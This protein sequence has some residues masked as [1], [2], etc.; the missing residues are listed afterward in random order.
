M[1]PYEIIESYYNK[2]SLARNI[3]VPHS[4]A[5]AKKALRMAG[6][7]PELN[8]DPDFIFE[9]AMLHDIGIWLT[10]APRLGCNGGSPY[11]CHGYLGAEVLRDEGYPKHALVS[12][13]HVGVGISRLDIEQLDIPV[14]RRDMIP[15]SVEEQIVCWADN[16]FIKV[17]G[18]LTDEQTVD[19]II[20][21]QSKY[22]DDK[23]KRIQEFVQIFGS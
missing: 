11:I 1:N 7:V 22:G 16:F 4:Q 12:E 2:N 14:P 19:Q 5:V 13:R 20:L 3:L 10:N 18:H 23:V 17:A 9:A 6:R 8:P 15:L 21:R